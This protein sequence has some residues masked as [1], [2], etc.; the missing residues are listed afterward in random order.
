VRASWVL[1]H[2]SVQSTAE[3]K[4]LRSLTWV[5]RQETRPLRHFVTASAFEYLLHL[6]LLDGD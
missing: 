5:D 4:A 3:S 6:V 1:G 2:F